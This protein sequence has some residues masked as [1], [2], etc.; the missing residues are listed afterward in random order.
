MLSL[1]QQH[2]REVKIM[3]ITK[4]IEKVVSK[5]KVVNYRDFSLKVMDEFSIGT[6]TC[7]DYVGIALNR[8]NLERGDI[9]K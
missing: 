5:F 2:K 4:L 7:S 3:K 6:R 8:L 9:F 1:D